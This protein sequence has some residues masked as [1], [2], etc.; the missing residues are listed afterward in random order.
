M[1]L[2]T[3]ATLDGLLQQSFI[4][5]HYFIS[6]VDCRTFN[7]WYGV[8]LLI[9]NRLQ[10][11]RML[12]IDFPNSSMGRRLVMADIQMQPY[13]LLRIGTVHLESLNNQQQ[14]SAQLQICQHA[15]E[16]DSP[17]GLILMGDFNFSDRHQEN[18][19]QF[20]ILWKWTDVWTSL[21][22][23]DE[24]RYTFDTEMNLMI[25]RTHGHADRSR[26]DRIIFQSRTIQPKM[27][28]IIGKHSVGLLD[29]RPVFVSDHFG[30]IAIFQLISSKQS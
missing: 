21:V 3:K 30:L 4:Q 27:I 1:N 15:F 18:V 7:S 29:H 24:Y 11:K 28:D 20:H 12:L 22:Y 25:R 14:R 10:T 16:K 8:I 17:S 9:S 5:K 23:S 6:D 2:V 13:E 26:Y 19:A